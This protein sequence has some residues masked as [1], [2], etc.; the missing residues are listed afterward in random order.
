MHRVHL[1]ASPTYKNVHPYPKS[2]VRGLAGN[3]GGLLSTC[4]V[5]AKINKVASRRG[6]P[7][8]S[9]P[10][11]TLR[12]GGGGGGNACI[13]IRDSFFTRLGVCI[14]LVIEGDPQTYHTH[15]EACSC[16]CALCQGFGMPPG[17]LLSLFL[18]VSSK[19]STKAKPC[20]LAPGGVFFSCPPESHV[21]PLGDALVPIKTLGNLFLC[22]REDIV[23]NVC[24]VVS[25]RRRTT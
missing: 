16:G 24:R 15:S 7:H 25:G 14:H 17:K 22:T 23:Q 2:Q 11:G 4:R 13:G 20:V 21:R 10:G 18:M 6:S 1:E 3:G 12:T 5:S 8:H 9:S 19:V